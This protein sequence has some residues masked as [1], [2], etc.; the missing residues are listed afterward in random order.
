MEGVD[1]GCGLRREGVRIR[2]E[3]FSG[4]TAICGPPADFAAGRRRRA[5][6]TFEKIVPENFSQKS[7]FFRPKSRFLTKFCRGA[8]DLTFFE[9]N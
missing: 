1:L 4:V 6:R 5:G 9:A 7:D 8:A 3:M 2:V